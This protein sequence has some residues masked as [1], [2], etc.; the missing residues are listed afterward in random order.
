MPTTSDVT[1]NAA[2]FQAEQID[3]STEKFNKIIAGDRG[4]HPKWYEVGA[5]VFRQNAK[6]GKGPVPIPAKLPNARDAAIPSRVPGRDI[7]VRVYVPDDGK[8]SRGVF[9]YLHGGGFVVGTHQDA[10]ELLKA[11]ANNC[12]L[13]SISVGYRLAPEDPFPAGL[14]DC[15]D[16]AEH[17]VDKAP[18]L[19]GAPLKVLAGASAGGNYA[20]VTTFQLLRSRPQ[21]RLAAV[22]LNF[23]F[24]DL[25]L[26]MPST[27]Q[28]AEALVVDSAMLE[29]FVAAYVGGVSI[30]GRRAP[31]IS[32]VYEDLRRLVD[33]SPFRTL[34]PALFNCGTADPLLDDSLLM[35][36]KWISTGSEAVV[37]LYP[38]SPHGFTAFKGSKMA[39]EAAAVTEEWLRERLGESE[40]GI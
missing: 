15:I 16:V 37:K 30:E 32:P 40:T 26:N 33:E 29:H 4:K 23:G 12:Q 19:F 24:F 14:N 5:A 34:P 11:Y 21:F 18:E 35:S 20:A 8:P 31:A 27:V 13:T 22:L 7:P 6:E 3:A 38:G 39:E 2:K 10:D 9:L 1:V 28:G 25:T 17:L 36:M